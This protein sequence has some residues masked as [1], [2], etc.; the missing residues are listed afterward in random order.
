MGART[1]EP[2]VGREA[3]WARR[4]FS[5]GRPAAW[6]ACDRSRKSSCRVT[7]PPRTVNSWNTETLTATP[8][9]DPRPLC[10]ALTR[11]L[12]VLARWLPRDHRAVRGPASADR[13]GAR[14]RGRVVGGHCHATCRRSPRRSHPTTLSEGSPRSPQK[15]RKDAGLPDEPTAAVAKSR[16]GA[17]EKA[18]S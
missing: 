17:A 1:A 18:K 14:S 13:R 2:L 7:R 11:F 10:R 4:H 12:P 9:P 15:L 3:R 8:L 6:R 5:L 16:R